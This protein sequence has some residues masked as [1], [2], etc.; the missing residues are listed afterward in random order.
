[1]HG[2]R[3]VREWVTAATLHAVDSALASA[4]S[5][6]ATCALYIRQSMTLSTAAAGLL[7]QAGL[8]RRLPG[9]GHERSPAAAGQRK[10]GAGVDSLL[11]R[12]VNKLCL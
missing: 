1:M 9:S 12:L 2:F 5:S 6:E 10:Q 7:P 3:T 8:Y 11:V 4:C